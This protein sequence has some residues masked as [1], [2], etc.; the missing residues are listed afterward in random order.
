[1]LSQ[2]LGGRDAVGGLEGAVEITDTAKSRLKGD[3]GDPF[4]GVL[5]HQP[6][7]PGCTDGINVYGIRNTAFGLEGAAEIN[8]MDTKR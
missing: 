3:L 8:G 6:S 1:M 5:V 2:K 7:R 4:F